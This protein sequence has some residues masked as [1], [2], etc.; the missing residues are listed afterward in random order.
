MND[1]HIRALLRQIARLVRHLDAADRA[2]A[3]ARLLALKADLLDWSDPAFEAQ[4]ACP[5]DDDDCEPGDPGDP[6]GPPGGG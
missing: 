2:R 3:T 1:R 4:A 5:P 6:G